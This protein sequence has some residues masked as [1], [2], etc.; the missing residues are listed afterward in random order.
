MW[1]GD[2]KAVVIAI[3]NI[4]DTNEIPNQSILKWILCLNE[5][6]VDKMV[7]GI[8]TTFSFMEYSIH[9]IYSK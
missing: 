6:Q 2:Y 8:S 4:Y 9:R 1:L 7:G 3:A 5:C